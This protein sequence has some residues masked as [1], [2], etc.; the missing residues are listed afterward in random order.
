MSTELVTV[1]NDDMS[2]AEP[3]KSKK[4]AMSLEK[5]V[6][7][8]IISGI[9][10]F[11][12]SLIR[13][14]VLAHQNPNSQ[15]STIS[16][17]R[18]FPG[19]LICPVGLQDL[20]SRFQYD[21]FINT[22]DFLFCPKWSD[23]ASLSFDFGK[24]NPSLWN[25][26]FNAKSGRQGSVCPKNN[27]GVISG[28]R[29]ADFQKETLYFLDMTRRG[30]QYTQYVT[31]KSKPP[32]IPD[33]QCREGIPQTPGCRRCSSWMPPNVRCLA[34]D[35]SFFNSMAP[36]D[37]INPI[38]NPM[39]EGKD[40]NSLDSLHLADVRLDDGG[41]RY[42]GLI[43]QPTVSEVGRADSELFVSFFDL[44]QEFARP[45][46]PGPVPRNPLNTTFFGGLVTIFYDSSK[47]IPKEL[48]FAAA[49][50]GTPGEGL[51]SL[52]LLKTFE[53]QKGKTKNMVLVTPSVDV[54]I[55]DFNFDRSFSNVVL[56][57][58]ADI[59]TQFDIRMASHKESS[60]VQR[61]EDILYGTVINMRFA[62]SS[63]TFRQ[64]SI[65]LSIIA[66]IS[67]ILSTATTVWSAR[68]KVEQIVTWPIVKYRRSCMKKR[69]QRTVEDL[70]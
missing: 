62:S 24:S 34:Y 22:D 40:A 52:Q 13:D 23:D 55:F 60:H 28:G 8:F 4:F 45:P 41:F 65:S 9:I 46:S 44:K 70:L 58:Y 36:T 56:Q 19:I 50:I 29:A 35:P 18:S 30:S 48:D 49:A 32:S 67:I 5:V 51:F 57:L 2:S 1:N 59:R 27:L 11:A 68:K 14:C 33:S 38:C 66:T 37:G 7:A 61:P 17:P 3:V 10:L 20:D 69:D 31:V 16:R 53:V 39:T 64:E 43:Q 12:S 6:K 47:G 26:N 15:I 21:N 54:D 42:S 63:S 25:T